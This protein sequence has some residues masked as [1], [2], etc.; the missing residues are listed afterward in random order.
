MHCAQ[1]E[2]QQL[3]SRIEGKQQLGDLVF[4]VSGISL[5]EFLE[6]GKKAAMTTFG[7]VL[8]TKLS[9]SMGIVLGNISCT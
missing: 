8:I 4:L 3:K 5:Q 9:F 6:L 7:K 2:S 1:A